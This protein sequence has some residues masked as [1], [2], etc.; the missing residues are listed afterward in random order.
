MALISDATIII[1]ASEKCVDQEF[2]DIIIGPLKSFFV[3]PT[4]RIQDGGRFYR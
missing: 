2:G 1:E 3:V 4:L